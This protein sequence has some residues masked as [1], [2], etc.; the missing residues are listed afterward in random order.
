MCRRWSL[1]W[2]RNG[3]TFH[4]ESI[5]ALGYAF[6][7]IAYL[8]RVHTPHSTHADLE[9]ERAVLVEEEMR[10]ALRLPRR[11]YTTGVYIAANGLTQLAEKYA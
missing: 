10:E 8:S 3:L 2:E 5:H 11:S 1:E 7:P 9:E 4:H 6:D